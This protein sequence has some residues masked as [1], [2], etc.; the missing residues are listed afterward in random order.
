MKSVVLFLS[1]IY[2]SYVLYYQ[3]DTYFSLDFRFQSHK[4]QTIKDFEKCLADY[5]SK[6]CST[7][8]GSLKEIDGCSQ[9]LE[10]IERGHGPALFEALPQ[11]LVESLKQSGSV[12][13]SLFVVFLLL[14]RTVS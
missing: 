13:M 3:I 8:V 7:K 5:S 9:A 2:F 14:S 12:V 1:I 4:A 11:L 10:C 6:L